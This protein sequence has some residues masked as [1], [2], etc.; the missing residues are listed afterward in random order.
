MFFRLH[1]IR[2]GVAFAW[3]YLD[4]GCTTVYFCPGQLSD[5]LIELLP[6]DGEECVGMK[7]SSSPDRRETKG[8]TRPSSLGK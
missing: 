5:S 4:F 7:P 8:W 6:S 1:R 2:R 3:P